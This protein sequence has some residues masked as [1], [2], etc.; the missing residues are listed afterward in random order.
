MRLEL[1]GCSVL[2][3]P[4]SALLLIQQ[5]GKRP[6]QPMGTVMIPVEAALAALP[7]PKQG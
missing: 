7:V 6:C 3:R 4:Q 2:D 5:M 1:Q